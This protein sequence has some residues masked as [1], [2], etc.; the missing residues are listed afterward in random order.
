MTLLKSALVWTY[1]DN[2]DLFVGQRVYLDDTTGLATLI[3]S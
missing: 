3:T 2:E 1:V